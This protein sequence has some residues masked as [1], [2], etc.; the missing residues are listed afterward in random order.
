MIH[1]M[2]TIFF[3]LLL[4][5]AYLVNAQLTVTTNYREEGKWNSDN[6]EWEITSTKR[7]LTVLNFNKDLTSFRHITETVASVYQILDWDYNDEEVLYEMDVRSDAGNE[8]ELLIDGLNAYV[9]FFYYDSSG[10][11]RM[12]RHT[13]QDT[14]Y[15]E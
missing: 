14:W 9:I 15:D 5:A 11:Y 8:Y 10:N 3:T 13:L 4:S 7:G 1:S 12:V 6:F 2:K